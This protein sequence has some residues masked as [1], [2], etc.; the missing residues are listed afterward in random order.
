MPP[1]R[2]HSC[3]CCRTL[4][5]SDVPR[6]ARAGQPGNARKPHVDPLRYRRVRPDEFKRWVTR[7]RK[8]FPLSKPVRCFLSDPGPDLV[9]ICWDGGSS[10]VVKVC[11]RMDRHHAAE[12]LLH[13][14]VHLT[15]GDE[16]PQSLDLHDAAYWV[17]YGEMYRAWH[18]TT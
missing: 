16:D 4:A 17:K 3:I 9:G 2:P 8:L 5:I 13:E 11:P 15:R 12:T 18:R 14:W 10:Y 1:E 6:R 7:M